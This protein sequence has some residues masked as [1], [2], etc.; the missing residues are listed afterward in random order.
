GALLVRVDRTDLSKNIVRG[1]R[2]YG[3]MLEL[4]PGMR[5]R[6]TFLAQLQPSRGDI[7]E[8][9]AYAEAIRESAGEVNE[10]FGTPSW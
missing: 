10:A 1:F 6:V 8:Y 5:G 7:P 2:A 4:N 9:A 3:R